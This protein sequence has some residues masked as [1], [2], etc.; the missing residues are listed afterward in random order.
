METKT[1]ILISAIAVVAVLVF[2]FISWL[3]S[4]RRVVKPSEVHVVRRSK[5][6]EIYGNVKPV[7]N[8]ATGEVAGGDDSSGNVYYHIPTWVPIWGVE[9]QVLP[10]HNFSVDLEGYEAYDK[11]KLP[12]VVD[13][14]AFFR[15]ADYKQAASRIEDNSTLE[16]HL[17]KI[18][19][20]SVR[21][22][23]ANDTLDEIMIQRSRYGE[24]FTKEV[25]DNLK[26]WGVVP[27]KSIELMDVRDKEDEKVISNIMEKKKSFIDMESRREVAK[28]NKE[29]RE[30]EIAAE[31]SIA[32]KEEEKQE[33]VGKRRAEREKSVGIAQEK[34]QQDIQEQA[35]TTKE[36]QMAVLQVETVKKADIEKERTVIEANASR[37]R[38]KIEAD[39][40]VDVAERQKDAATH[41][42]DALY[43]QKTKEA[44]AELVREQNIAKAIEV[45]GLAEATAKEKTGLAEVQPQITLAKEIGENEG[46]QKYLIEIK[47]VEAS[48]AVGV[49]QA[50]NLGTAQIKIIANAGSSIPE[51]VNSVMDL[52]TAKGGQALGSMLEAFAGTEAGQQLLSKLTKNEEK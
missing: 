43:I 52:F 22:I 48:Q 41:E 11:D 5:Q 37:E 9:V 40:K 8:A 1:I 24:E 16:E 36:K 6:T 49:E 13:V 39:A 19:Q 28:N 7:T 2:W 4:K 31:Q 17:T 20:S 18:V 38:Q 15:I 26:E 3:L 14:T 47:K 30:A 10:L 23:L 27:V 29:A 42:A 32:M 12:F 46:Y 34:A 33:T 25:S 35:K 21:S 45:K 50:K 51:G 44:E